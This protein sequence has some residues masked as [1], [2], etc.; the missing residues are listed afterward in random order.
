MGRVEV[1]PTLL[2]TGQL[3]GNGFAPPPELFGLG[4]QGVTLAF[5]RPQRGGGCRFH[6]GEVRHL[7]RSL[8]QLVVTQRDALLQFGCGC[9]PSTGCLGTLSVELETQ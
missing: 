9:F 5:A 1:L 8:R 7:L 2:H 3:R 6:S 4:N